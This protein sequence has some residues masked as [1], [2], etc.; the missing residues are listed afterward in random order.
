MGTEGQDL[1]GE[2]VTTELGYRWGREG[3]RTGDRSRR[4]RSRKGKEVR[5]ILGEA[6]G[7]DDGAE[8]VGGGGGS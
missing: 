3:G 5:E 8:E 6:G 4:A 2:A 1:W 7:F